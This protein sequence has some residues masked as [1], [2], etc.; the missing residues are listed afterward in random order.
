MPNTF[1]MKINSILTFRHPD[2]PTHVDLGCTMTERC[3]EMVGWKVWGDVLVLGRGT[4]ITCCQNGSI[5]VFSPDYFFLLAPSTEF[6]HRSAWSTVLETKTTI[7]KSFLGSPGTSVERH[8]T[9]IVRIQFDT[10]FNDPMIQKSIV[11]K[12]SPP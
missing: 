4:R 11:C 12:A 8:V 6:Y 3:A 1:S 7:S 2:R 9:L 5:S 10:N